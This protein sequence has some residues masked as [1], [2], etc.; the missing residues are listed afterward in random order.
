MLR[1]S[2]QKKSELVIKDC[3]ADKAPILDGFTMAIWGTVKDNITHAFNIFL[4]EGRLERA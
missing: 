4:D 3:N 2:S 1:H